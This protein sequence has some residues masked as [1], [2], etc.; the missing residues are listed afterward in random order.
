MVDEW[1]LN[2]LARRTDCFGA[3]ASSSHDGSPNATVRRWPLGERLSPSSNCMQI[4]CTK[5]ESQPNDVCPHLSTEIN[6]TQLIFLF[7]FCQHTGSRIQQNKAK[8]IRKALKMTVKRPSRRLR[9]DVERRTS[10]FPGEKN[11]NSIRAQ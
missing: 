4:I 1:A 3:D 2:R 11:G 10:K 7:L 9:H 6:S 5:T 8:N